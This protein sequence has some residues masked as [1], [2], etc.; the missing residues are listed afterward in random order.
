[1]TCGQA[2]ELIAA[3]WLGELENS[4]QPMFRQH[5]ETCAECSAEMAALDGLWARLGDMPAP[6]PG[7]SPSGWRRCSG[8]A[9]PF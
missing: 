1:M 9:C 2:K 5:L 3:A 6:E 8:S 4:R 7:P